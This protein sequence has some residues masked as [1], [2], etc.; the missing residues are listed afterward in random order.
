M[1]KGASGALFPPGLNQLHV[2]DTIH[3]AF[4]LWI[5]PMTCSH[6]LLNDV[7]IKSRYSFP[8]RAFIYFSFGIGNALSLKHKYGISRSVSAY[9]AHDSVEVILHG[10]LRRGS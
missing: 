9:D 10:N 5:S 3:T 7:T 2:A 8:R 6:I 1:P 4:C